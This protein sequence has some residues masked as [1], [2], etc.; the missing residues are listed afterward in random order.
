[1]NN[2]SFLEM[3]RFDCMYYLVI[4]QSDWSKFRPIGDILF[5]AKIM[6]SLAL[7]SPYLPTLMT[8]ISYRT[9]FIVI[10]KLSVQMT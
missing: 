5:F 2:Q 10:L 8:Y 6:D 3:M 1:M 4:Y 7:K 9:S